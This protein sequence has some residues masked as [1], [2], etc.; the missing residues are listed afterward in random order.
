M[1]K[2]LGQYTSEYEKETNIEIMNKEYDRP[3]VE[4]LKDSFKSLEFMPEI[5]ILGF[6]YNTDERTIDINDFIIKRNKKRK[7]K[8]RVNYKF[9][10]DERYGS[11]TATVQITVEEPAPKDGVK[12]IKQCTIPVKILVPIKD[13]DGYYTIKGKKYLMIYQLVDKSLYSTAQTVTVKSLMPIAIKRVPVTETDIHGNEYKLPLYNIFIF[14]KEINVLMLYACEGLD[15]AFQFLGVHNIMSFIDMEG[16]DE[17]TL[18]GDEK[19]LYFRI[20]ASVYLKV[21]KQLFDEF[22]YVKAMVGMTMGIV[23]NRFTMDLINDKEHWIKKLGGMNLSKGES[24]RLSFARLLDETTKQELKINEDDKKDIYSLIRW[25]MMNFNELRQKDN[26]SLENKRLRCNEYIASLLTMEFSSRIIR[27][28]SK[29]PKADM[30][31]FKDIFKFPG[32]ILISAMHRSGILRFDENI[33]DM[34]FFSKFRWSSKGP[35]SVGGKN[36][37]NIA[38]TQRGIYPSFL[39]Y[40]DVIVSGNSDPGTSGVLSPFTKLKSLYF[41]EDNEPDDFRFNFMKRIEEIL[42]KDGVDYIGIKC[43]N[44]IDFYNLMSMLDK[45]NK[46]VT[47]YGTSREEYNIVIDNSKMTDSSDDSDEDDDDIADDS[48]LSED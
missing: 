37:N 13:E 30:D 9:T 14:R 25:M 10:A 34:D 44:K 5:K 22:V 17:E 18:M 41:N 26:L 3:L 31:T 32:D 28:I 39:G 7:K 12:Q 42:D 36:S 16:K 27:V 23:S 33:N 40:I 4:Y 48:D 47:A 2:Y 15:S 8:E 35:H 43:D 1:R 20:S 29:G 11:L 24:L 19:N 46:H 21:N 6:D 45:S 38:I